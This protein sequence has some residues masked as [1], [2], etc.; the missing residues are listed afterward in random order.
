MFLIGISSGNGLNV[1]DG[2]WQT[3]GHLNGADAA[4]SN[5]SCHNVPN[6]ALLNS[7]RNDAVSVTASNLWFQDKSEEKTQCD[8]VS[9]KHH[10]H[11]DAAADVA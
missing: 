8:T 1:P 10:D 2:A 7:G 9:S 4:Q 11:E 3:E 5:E 6:R